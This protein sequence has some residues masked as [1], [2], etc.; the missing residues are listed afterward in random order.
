MA[1]AERV[2][3]G[4]RILTMD[5]DRPVVEALAVRDGRIIATGRD[6]DIDSLAGPGTTREDLHG[7][8]VEPPFV[9]RVTARGF[10]PPPQPAPAWR[11]DVDMVLTRPE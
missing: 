3:T 11:T 7:L 2:F 8:H 10:T 4:G 5:P 1:H 6:A 9:G